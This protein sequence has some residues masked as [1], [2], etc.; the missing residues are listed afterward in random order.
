MYLHY[1]PSFNIIYHLCKHGF[2]FFIISSPYIMSYIHIYTYFWNEF[3]MFFFSHHVW[4]FSLVFF[5]YI[6][7]LYIVFLVFF[8]YFIIF[9]IR[10]TNIFSF[11]KLSILHLYYCIYIYICKILERYKEDILCEKYMCTRKGNNS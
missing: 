4:S 5:F 11:Q 10:T 8:I 7:F 6:H 9:P 2:S 1:V 3:F